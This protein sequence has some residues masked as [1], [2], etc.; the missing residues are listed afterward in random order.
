[1]GDTLNTVELEKKIKDRFESNHPEYGCIY[2]TKEGTYINLYP[3]IDTHEDLCW[4]IEDEYGVQLPY[5]DEEWAIREFDWI[6][7]RE[8]PIAENVIELPKNE[9]TREQYYAVRTWL[10]EIVSGNNL[11]IGVVDTDKIES[12][13]DLDF[14]EP[15]DII[16]S[17]RK[18]YSRG[19]LFEGLWS[20]DGN[21]YQPTKDAKYNRLQ[22]KA[23]NTLTKDEI[24][25]LYCVSWADYMQNAKTYEN[26]DEILAT[27]DF[28]WLDSCYDWLSTLSFP[29]TVYRAIT[30]KEKDNNK[31]NGRSWTTDI[32][33]YTQKNSIFKNCKEIVCGEITAESIHNAYTIENYK[34]YTYK[35]EYGFAPESE[36]TMKKNFKIDNLREVN[37]SKLTED[38]F[39]S[40]NGILVY[41]GAVEEYKIKTDGTTTWFTE[42]YA[43]ANKY[44]STVWTAKIY[45]KNICD[46][47][48]TDKRLFGILPTKPY[49]LSADGSNFLKKINVKNLDDFLRP[50]LK[51]CKDKGYIT[52]DLDAYLYGLRIY[53]IVRTKAFKDYML[54]LGYDCIKTIEEQSNI[55]YG[56]LDN[57]I[58]EWVDEKNLSES[59]PPLKFK[60]KNDLIKEAFMAGYNA[61]KKCK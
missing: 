9:I 28:D 20:K 61:G 6:R 49:K 57:S 11:E 10:E 18:Y 27:N 36:I 59:L 55:C 38:N 31:I 53:T 34:Y 42:Q 40:D 25:Y 58:I 33:L 22:N 2:I 4:W 32:S 60:D 3:E 30:N 16:N 26:V 48:C 50:I 41:R 54:G 1:M 23:I 13:E 39:A 24:K 35:P 29:L 19:E 12:F 8:T 52:D 51:E 15:K 46:L 43:Y 45:P 44:S 56:V 37:L 5:E 17:I 47:G 21:I 7:C 14:I